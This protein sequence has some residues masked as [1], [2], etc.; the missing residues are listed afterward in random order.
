MELTEALPPDYPFDYYCW[1]LY[2][3]VGLWYRDGNT[4]GAINPDKEKIRRET[5]HLLEEGNNP[6]AE[7]AE[8]V[9]TSNV[10]CILRT[11]ERLGIRY[12]L[13]P[14]ES[15][16]LSLKF[17]QHAFDQMKALGVIRLENE[18]RNAGCWVMPLDLHSGT[19][20]H[21]ADKILVRSNGTVTYTGKDIAYQLWKLGRLDLDFHYKLFHTYPDGQQ[22]WVTV[23]KPTGETPP[24]FGN[25]ATVYNVIDT[26]QSYPQ[27]VVKLGVAAIAP[28][29]G[30]DASVH[31]SYEM[32]A[33]SPAAAEQL[34]FVLSAEDKSRN[35]I[36]M[37]GRK[38]LGVKADDLIN[39]L[40]AS[41]LSEVS[42]RHPDLSSEAQLLTARIL[43]VGA[44]R[45]FL[46]KYTRNSLIV[47]DFKEA[48]A[49]EGE[50]G[51][52]CQYAVV[53]L[54]SIFRKLGSLKHGSAHE[55][56]KQAA[57]DAE[58]S[59]AISEILN[60]GANE[61][62]WELVILAARLEEVVNLAAQTAEPAHLAKYCF[63]LAKTFNLFFHRHRIIQE[64]DKY[65]QAVLIAAAE[66]TRRQLTKGLDIL[67]ISV[68][69]RM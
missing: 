68:P 37:A 7:L 59:G 41:A 64:A 8:F 62:I 30:E 32:V 38:G 19:D 28:D 51:A 42:T 2:T 26:R 24:P 11:M 66:I 56:I 69:E 53:R 45:Y 52:Y 6:T 61:D 54:N 18:G 43:A 46:L 29:A 40:E 16:I 49:F 67:G 48:L 33:L 60:D 63:H 44:L 39:Q 17:W 31:L 12:D 4:N 10:R 21:D 1:D 50:T 3:K 58:V 9:A 15:E 22:T 57:T 25:G 20:E 14:R 47:F 36:E 13:L 34:G 55:I 5:L 35:F 65:R 27:K 23:D